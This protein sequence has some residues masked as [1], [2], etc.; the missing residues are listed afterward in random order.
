MRLRPMCRVVSKW[1]NRPQLFLSCAGDRN[2]GQGNDSEIPNARLLTIG[3]L[4]QGDVTSEAARDIDDTALL[5]P[6]GEGA[7]RMDAQNGRG[8]FGFSLHDRD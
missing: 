8:V 3:E 1:R 5:V 4:A 6:A 7:L 2:S